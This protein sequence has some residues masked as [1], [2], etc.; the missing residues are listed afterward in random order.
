MALS[1]DGESAGLLPR[2]GGIVEGAWYH[3]GP[4]S[5]LCPAAASGSPLPDGAIFKSPWKTLD[6]VMTFLYNG[7]NQTIGATEMT[8]STKDTPAYTAYC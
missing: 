5:L 8:A 2:H 4:G 7:C 6:I 3:A 1:A